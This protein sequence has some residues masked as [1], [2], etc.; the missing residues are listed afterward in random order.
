MSKCKALRLGAKS[1]HSSWV[2]VRHRIF[3]EP[4]ATPNSPLLRLSPYNSH[5]HKADNEV[6]LDELR[7]A[8]DIA[9]AI[10]ER[11]ILNFLEG[12]IDVHE[13]LQWKLRSLAEN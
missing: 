6:L 4:A 9:E 7:N 1:K 8:A 2:L 11:G 10:K 13:T 3:Y 5:F 12:Q